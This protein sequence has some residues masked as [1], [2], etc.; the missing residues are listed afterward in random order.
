MTNYSNIEFYSVL[1]TDR[2]RKIGTD[3]EYVEMH[4]T[5]M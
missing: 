5:W 2:E 4:E 1:D 3:R